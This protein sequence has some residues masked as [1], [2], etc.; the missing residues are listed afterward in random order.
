VF[1]KAH[2]SIKDDVKDEVLNLLTPS[3]AEGVCT[4]HLSD[5]R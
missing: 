5:H 3:L 4:R 2:F 1:L